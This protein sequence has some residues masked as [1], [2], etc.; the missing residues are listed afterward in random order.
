[1][2]ARTIIS[3]AILIVLIVLTAVLPGRK[4]SVRTA[5]PCWPS[6]ALDPA[7]RLLILAPHPDDEVLGCGG[8]IQQAVTMKL[9]VRIVF[10]TYGDFYEWSFLRYEKRPVLTPRGV[11]GM[12]EI[13]RGEAL[14]A[15]ATLGV[16]QAD[17]AFL[18]CPWPTRSRRIWWGSW[19]GPRRS[20]ARAWYSRSG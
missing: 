8:V 6:V 7:D 20:R 5:D 4:E 18:G 2:G 13:R 1:M 15:D 19:R 10:L 11:Q 16:A 9:P 12:G 14:A 17:L 3:A